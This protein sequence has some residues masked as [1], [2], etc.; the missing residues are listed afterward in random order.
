[1]ETLKITPSLYNSFYWC[2]KLEK[3]LTEFVDTLLRKPRE[4]NE[5]MQA[6]IDFENAVEKFCETGL[7]PFESVQNGYIENEDVGVIETHNDISENE[8]KYNDCVVEVANMVKGGYW[9][10]TVSKIVKIPEYDFN[11]NLTGRTD[12]I[13]FD[14]INDIKFVKQY[15]IGKYQAGIQHLIY[16]YCADIEKFRY[17]ISDG[18]AVYVEDY[19]FNMQQLEAKLFLMVREFLSFLQNTDFEGKNLMQI[20]KNKWVV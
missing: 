2:M 13:G 4:S 20:Y 6:G 8:K 9:Q 18:K 11:I 15:E 5:A 17:I 12:V 7:L 19:N 1:M 16:M 14:V 10:E 3:P